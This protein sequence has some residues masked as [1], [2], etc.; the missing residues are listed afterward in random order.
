MFLYE[1]RKHLRLKASELCELQQTRFR[2]LLNH[3]YQNVPF[4]HQKF[5]MAGIK[6]D[7]IR[8][9]ND[10]AKIPITTKAEIQQNTQKM[11]A[12]NFDLTRCI[13]RTTSGSTGVP[14]TVLADQ[15]TVDFENALRI[16]TM[17]E[18]GWRLSDKDLVIT[19]PRHFYR[20]K[21]LYERLG[22]M[23]QKHVSIF[24]DAEKQL[25]VLKRYSPDV[26][27]G[28][29]SSLTLL[30]NAY[31]K[32]SSEVRPRLIFTSGEMLD[33]GS[34]TLISSTFEAE[35]LDNYGTTECPDMAWECSKHSGYHMNIDN[36]LIEFVDK[37]GEPVAPGERGNIV[38]TNLTNYAMP[39]IRYS[40]DDIGVFVKEQ[41][42]CGRTLPL[43]KSIEGRADDFLSA[44]DGRSISPT[45][46]FPYPFESY[47]GIKQFRI[48][49][50]KRDELIIQLVLDENFTENALIWDKATKEIKRVFGDGMN[51][52]FLIVDEIPREPS[53][54]CRKV[55]SRFKN[56]AG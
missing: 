28:Y 19:D 18:S 1:L 30:A 37:D 29:P 12:K 8:S 11:F 23:R 46:F 52:Q 25:A 32:T 53:G 31:T 33:S 48:I 38:C 20:G 34:R 17:L 2:A 4:Y 21:H 49:Q 16:R 22:V 24:D 10:I 7:K 5:K 35:V 45:I 9:V 51:V 56:S 47:A 42:E 50:D 41:C 43:M 14:L 27:T 15:K 44:T 26:I 39:L 55:V 36:A 13:K 3:A 40:L 54:K 6:N